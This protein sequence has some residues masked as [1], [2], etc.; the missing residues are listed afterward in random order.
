[1]MSLGFKIGITASRSNRITSFLLLLALPISVFCND[2]PRSVETQNRISSSYC[3]SIMKL[4]LWDQKL[5]MKET[6]RAYSLIPKGMKE[7]KK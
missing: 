4:R 1:M 7:R 5:M 2:R 6:K 3:S